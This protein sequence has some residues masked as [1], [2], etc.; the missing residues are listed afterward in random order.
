MEDVSFYWTLDPE[1]IDHYNKFPNQTRNPR[2]AVYEDDEMFFGTEETQPELFAPENREYVEFY[3]FEGFENSVKKFK[4]RLQNFKNTD[5]PFF[6]SIL[7]GVMFKISEGKILEN[8]KVN[9]VLGKNFY[10]E[11]LE[12]KDDIQLD[13][14]L[15]EYFGR[16]FLVNIVL[17]KYNFFLKVFEKRDKF[18]FLIKKKFN[19]KIK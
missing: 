17:G 1:N 16:C 9:D 13:K 18:R 5:N 14:I 12:I 10:E 4:D 2:D 7:Y 15:F 19:V 8:N 3:K 6:D 11:L